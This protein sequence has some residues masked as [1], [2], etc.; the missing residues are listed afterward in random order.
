MI[1]YANPIGRSVLGEA[2]MNLVEN[3]GTMVTP[4]HASSL[5]DSLGLAITFCQQLSKIHEAGFV[6]RDIKG[7][8]TMGN[9]TREDRYSKYDVNIVDLGLTIPTIEAQQIVE[10]CG[11]PTYMAPEAQQLGIQTP[12][13]DIFSAGMVLIKDLRLDLPIARGMLAPYPSGRP[14][15]PIVIEDLKIRYLLEILKEYSL[16]PKGKN[17]NGYNIGTALGQFFPALRDVDNITAVTYI[18]HLI[19]SKRSQ[20]LF[21]EVFKS[22]HGNTKLRNQLV[23]ICVPDFAEEAKW[24]DVISAHKSSSPLALSTDRTKTA[25]IAFNKV[26]DNPAS[27]LDEFKEAL[28]AWQTHMSAP[29]GSMGS[30]VSRR[31]KYYE[32]YM[33]EYGTRTPG[34]LSDAHVVDALDSPPSFGGGSGDHAPRPK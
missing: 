25:L 5:K 28:Q 15:L 24:M 22:L 14:Q 13:S 9:I 17:Q 11:T 21:Q 32:A 12:E 3:A 6:H 31:E 20:K 7:G 19:R 18:A 1:A 34:V 33:K 27:T 8:N 16:L 23:Q 4:M 30:R 29:S 2:A 26:L 10:H